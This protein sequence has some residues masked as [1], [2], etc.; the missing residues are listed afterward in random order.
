MSK[1][2]KTQVDQKLDIGGIEL[3]YEYFGVS[4]E[5]PTLVFDSGY[6][7]TL[8]Y[9]NP[10]RDEVSKFSKMFMYDRAGIGESTKDERPRHSQQIVKNLRTLLQK[11][12]V[13]PSY[14]LVGHSF[15][16]VNVRLY[17][18][19]YPEEVAGVILLD[20]S[21]EDQNKIMLPLY[22]KE[23]HDDYLSGFDFE[24]SL[25]EFEESLEQARTSKSLGN[26][27]LIVLTGGSQPHHTSESMTAWMSFQEDL[28]K[29][30]TNSKHIIVEDAGHAIHVDR[31]QVV[32]DAIKDMVEKIRSF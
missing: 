11:A 22:S 27:P 6:G 18:S 21:H 8:A 31:P 16:G 29:L 12:N 17:A 4:N 26:I 1:V 9:W 24:I 20:S 30:S 2:T 28:A 7:C 25:T 32:I 14:V 5:N 10:I 13:K 15:G 23:V 3:N 19:T